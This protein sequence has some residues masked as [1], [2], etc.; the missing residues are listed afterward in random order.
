VAFDVQVVEAL[1]VADEGKLLGRHG[2][3]WLY[4]DIFAGVSCGVLSA[5]LLQHADF[6]GSI[7]HFTDLHASLKLASRL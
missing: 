1:S 4:V 3:A 5:V 7:A 2:G 6:L